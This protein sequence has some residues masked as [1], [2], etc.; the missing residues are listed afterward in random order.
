MVIKWKAIISYGR[1]KAHTAVDY[2]QK[3][4]KDV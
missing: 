2:I 1:L 4:S 3:Y